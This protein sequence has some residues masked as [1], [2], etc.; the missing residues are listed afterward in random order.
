MDGPTVVALTRQVFLSLPANALMGRA[1]TQYEVVQAVNAV[2]WYE[3]VVFSWGW[4]ALLEDTWSLRAYLWLREKMVYYTQDASM[5]SV[6]MAL[7]LAFKL[8]YEESFEVILREGRRRAA[9][10]TSHATLHIDFL[11]TPPSLGWLGIDWDHLFCT[12]LRFGHAE[13]DDGDTLC[14]TIVCGSEKRLHALLRA[15][16]SK[17][18]ASHSGPYGLQTEYGWGVF[19]EKQDHT[20]LSLAKGYKDIMPEKYRRIL[21]FELTLYDRCLI[22]VRRQLGSLTKEKFMQLELP[23]TVKADLLFER[24]WFQSC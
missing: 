15:G 4:F 11:Y 17:F 21:G 12:I 2:D 1:L 23:Q 19:S 10:G 5:R 22:F 24:R 6:I 18:R 14:A 3:R 13:V 8:G 7:R 20:P 9:Y 16:A